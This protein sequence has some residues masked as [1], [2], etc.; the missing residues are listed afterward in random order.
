[1]TYTNPKHNIN[2]LMEQAGVRRQEANGT[3]KLF[4]RK[5]ALVK[6]GERSNAHVMESNTDIEFRLH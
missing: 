3:L 4:K 2:K 1:M 5:L 6:M